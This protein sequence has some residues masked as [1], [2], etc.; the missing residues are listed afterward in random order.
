MTSKLHAYVFGV[1]KP[2]PCVELHEY[3]APLTRKEKA[4]AWASKHWLD[5]A[6]G[7]LFA[8]VGAFY[9]QIYMFAAVAFGVGLASAMFGRGKR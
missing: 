5:V 4:S 3:S 2:E 1:V 8:S 7:S 9:P 6:I